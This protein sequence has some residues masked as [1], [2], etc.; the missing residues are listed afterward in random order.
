MKP[1]RKFYPAL[2][3]FLSLLSGG[4]YVAESFA[5]ETFFL[6]KPGCQFIIPN[7]YQKAEKAVHDRVESYRMS[8][9]PDRFSEDEKRKR[10]KLEAIFHKRLN[11]DLYPD[12]PFFTLQIRD[13]GRKVNYGDINIQRETFVKMQR[14]PVE[15]FKDIDAVRLL[16]YLSFTKF[17]EY[18]NTNSFLI[19]L[20]TKIAED[21]KEGYVLQYFK[22]YST[23]LIIFNFYSDKEAI[24]G[25]IQDFYTVINSFKLDNRA[26]VKLGR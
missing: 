4:R 15:I 12:R 5:S 21:E 23:G 19:M 20:S 8:L 14:D 2:L 18:K 11:K 7:G 6:P 3:F 9:Y 1:S 25:D 22:F 13:I 10:A 17:V 26:E 16:D 24:R